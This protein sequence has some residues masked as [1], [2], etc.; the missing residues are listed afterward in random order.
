MELDGQDERIDKLLKEAEA[1]LWADREKGVIVSAETYST[2]RQ[3]MREAE[4]AAEASS[5]LKKFTAATSLSI[6]LGAVKSELHG[7]K[8]TSSLLNRAR[9]LLDEISA[10]PEMKDENG[11]IRLD[12]NAKA[13]ILWEIRERSCAEHRKFTLISGE[14]N[15]F[16]FGVVLELA[17]KSAGVPVPERITDRY[18]IHQGRA[19]FAFK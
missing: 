18:R 5:P 10:C 13:E 15:P 2:L 3:R 19:S 8:S 17:A 11:E 6:I 7:E 1:V 9:D 4:S 12:K 16:V 14:L